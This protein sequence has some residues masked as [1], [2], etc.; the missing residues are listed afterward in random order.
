[1]LCRRSS[2]ALG[3]HWSNRALCAVIVLAAA[4]GPKPAANLRVADPV[5]LRGPQAHAL[6]P[7]E[8]L[9]AD[10]VVV[11]LPPLVYRVEPAGLADVIGSEIAAVANGSG[12]IVVSAG[13]LAT[14][15]PLSVRVVENL[16]AVCEPPCAARV[17]EPVTMSASLK[18]LEA[19]IAD[20]RFEFVVESGNATIDGTKVDF[21]QAGE[22]RIGAKAVSAFGE[23]LASPLVASV[24][25]HV[26][27]R[28][29]RMTLSCPWPMYTVQGRLEDEAPLQAPT[30]CTMEPGASTAL[31]VAAFDGEQAVVGRVEW[32]SSDPTVTVSPLGFVS[33]AP[34]GHALIRAKMGRTEV[35]LPVSILMDGCDTSRP[36]NIAANLP[37][38]M[39]ETQG[40][41]VTRAVNTSTRLQCQTGTG[42]RC[43]VAGFSNSNGGNVTRHGGNEYVD[44]DWG[45]VVAAAR[46]CCCI[47]S[48]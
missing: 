22:V 15:V 32:S 24:T 40:F 10:G 29:D 33:G 45:A 36:F 17:G 30:I 14:R 37:M 44:I 26:E 18:G 41:R 27:P 34:G 4:C 8:A 42:A 23:K 2:Q 20:A 6:P 3:L 43:I 46:R 19:A 38:T 31:R 28:V 21:Q 11:A 25:L 47:F 9:D 35:M 5:V 13:S 1:M 48:D 39:I 7:V 12:T 16:V